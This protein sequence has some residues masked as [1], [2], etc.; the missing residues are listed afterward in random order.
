M[1]SD[2]VGLGYIDEDG[3]TEGVETE[4][5]DKTDMNG[6]VILS[7]IRSEKAT[8]S[9]KFAE[10][11]RP[12][13]L[14]LIYGD[15]NVTVD[16]QSGAITVH[17]K[18]ASYVNKVLVREHVLSNGK[19]YRVIAPLAKIT[20]RGERTFKAGELVSFDTTWTLTKDVNGDRVVEYYE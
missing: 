16:A 11:V 20:E 7:E 8:W 2:F 6:D 3:I 1:T 15:A 18:G 5:E 19:R 13:V 12:E 10:A 14:K 4:S 9:F 17:D